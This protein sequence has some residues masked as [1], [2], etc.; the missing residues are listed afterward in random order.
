MTL[1]RKLLLVED[2]A[3]VRRVFVFML[4]KLG[5]E[6]HESSSGSAALAM[7][8]EVQPL[9]A[10][11]DVR[12]PDMNGVEVIRRIRHLESEQS[13]NPGQ[14]VVAVALTGSDDERQRENA[15]AAGFD[16]Y[17]VKPVDMK[18]VNAAIQSAVD[19]QAD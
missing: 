2:Q 10:V 14:P 5:Y 15:L 3:D 16:F 18:Q 11:V 8:P 1:P 4:E 12:L 6:V 13:V 19:R 9:A 7:F 17:F